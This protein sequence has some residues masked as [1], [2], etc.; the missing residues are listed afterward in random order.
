MK[1]YNIY[2]KSIQPLWSYINGEAKK[3]ASALYAEAK[4][5]YTK[6]LEY[7]NSSIEYYKAHDGYS[8]Y[9]EKPDSKKFYKK[10]H[11]YT[12]MKNS[13]QTFCRLCKQYNYLLP[14]DI[15]IVAEHALECF[16][17][18]EHSYSAMHHKKYYFSLVHYMESY[19]VAEGL[20]MEGPLLRKV[21]STPYSIRGDELLG[22]LDFAYSDII[23]VKVED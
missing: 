8:T 19:D 10:A 12:N 2:N 1:T 3:I 4:E 22:N 7:Y 13:L 11:A 9:P 17:N 5:E 20:S 23:L 15:V 14:W 18:F 6:A 21:G 16:K